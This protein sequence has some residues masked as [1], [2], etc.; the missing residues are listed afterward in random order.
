VA[1]L[2]ISGISRLI[3]SHQARARLFSCDAPVPMVLRAFVLGEAK[4][5]Y[6][7]PSLGFKAEPTG[8]AAETEM[9]HNTFDL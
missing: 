1:T 3:A 2:A 7:R 6:M 5:F 9:E 4:R 8:R